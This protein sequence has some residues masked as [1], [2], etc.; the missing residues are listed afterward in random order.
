MFLIIIRYLL[1][2][3]QYLKNKYSTKIIYYCHNFEA[4]KDSNFNPYV[5]EL[6]MA[7]MT[8]RF[9]APLVRGGSSKT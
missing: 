7:I 6:W 3:V 9:N 1:Y 2:K 8:M 4:V 5:Y